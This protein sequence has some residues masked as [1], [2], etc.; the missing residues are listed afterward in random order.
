MKAKLVSYRSYTKKSTGEFMYRLQLVV[1]DNKWEGGQ[2][3]R[4]V[5]CP[6]SILPEP[7]IQT[8][9]E[10]DMHLAQWDGKYWWALDNIMV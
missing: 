1:N 7:V 8:V 4:E 3:V 10:V 6:S 2:C 9:Y 5:S